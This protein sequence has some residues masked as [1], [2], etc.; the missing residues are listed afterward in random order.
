MK[1]LT[2]TIA[3]FIAVLSLSS[4]LCSCGEQVVPTFDDEPSE[5][6]EIQDQKNETDPDGED[7]GRP[8]RM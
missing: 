8:P 6:V 7:E 1:K 4:L 2:K 5:A 3:A